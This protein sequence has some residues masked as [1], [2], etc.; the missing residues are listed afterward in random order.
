VQM[1]IR[2]RS[3]TGF[4]AILLSTALIP[5]VSVVSQ[6]PQCKGNP[7]VVDACFLVHGRATYGAG[8]PALRIWPIG[9]KRM[10]GVTAGP[11]A[12][13]AGD[14]V[15]PK[16]M[17]LFKTGPEH[18]YGDFL[19]CPFTKQREGAMQ[20]VCVESASHLIVKDASSK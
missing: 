10:L 20:M 4:A 6:A 5:A 9:T 2:L 8:T 15:C 3:I 7:K 13:D 19:V 11:V 14:P 1:A 18:V 17:L 16:N 12:D